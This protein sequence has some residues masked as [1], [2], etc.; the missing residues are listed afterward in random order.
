MPKCPFCGKE[1]NSVHADIDEVHRYEFFLDGKKTL[2][3]KQLEVE[4][5]ELHAIYLC[6]ECGEELPF[7]SWR[8]EDFLRKEYVVLSL[9]D[10]EI[11]RKGDYV[12]YRGKVYKII[13]EEDVADLL[14]LKL[15]EDE[16]AADILKAN[17][18]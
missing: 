7:S 5:D 2:R 10:P 4:Q 1:I 11:K 8:V 15:V 13:R 16:L 6:P 9:D 18:E 12:L 14:H 3:R 17:I